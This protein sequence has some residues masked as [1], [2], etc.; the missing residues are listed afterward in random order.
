MR[1][2]L[3]VPDPVYRQLKATAAL[4]GCTL[5]DFVVRMMVRELAGRGPK[6]K[7]RIR[8]PLIESARPGSLHLTNKKIDEILFP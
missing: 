4:Q 8:L 1:T 7:R 3:D 5:K 6:K 2:T